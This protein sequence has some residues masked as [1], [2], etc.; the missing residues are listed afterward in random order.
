M[1]W[2]EEVKEEGEI[3]QKIRSKVF[4]V[5][6]KVEVKKQLSIEYFKIL[7][8]NSFHLRFLYIAKL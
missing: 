8:Q 4:Y 1:K 3:I 2:S 6:Q 7:K 5:S